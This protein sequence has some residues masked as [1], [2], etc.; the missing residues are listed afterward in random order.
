MNFVQMNKIR[1]C[2]AKQANQGV[3]MKRRI[4]VKDN[5]VEF[6][7]RRYCRLFHEFYQNAKTK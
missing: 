1:H 7:Q 6:G 2:E 4:L 3:R 5:K